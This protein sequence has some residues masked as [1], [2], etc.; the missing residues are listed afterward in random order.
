MGNT[1]A[2]QG[3]TLII[4]IFTG[5]AIGIFFDLFRV[6][7]RSFKTS[8]IITYLEDI[9]FWIA[10]G[11]FF[12]FVL[13]KFNNGQIRSYVVVGVLAGVILYLLFISK[14]F[15]KLNVNLMIKLKK[16]LSYPIRLLRILLKKILWPVSFIVINVRKGIKDIFKK[17]PNL[18]KIT[19]KIKKSPKNTKKKKGFKDLCRKIY[20]RGE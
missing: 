9:V 11:I 3:Y 4:F 18:T 6:L 2:I 13:F 15:I 7:R 19:K 20:N 17:I 10:T 5:I 1:I 16:V 12:L 8:N 14:Y